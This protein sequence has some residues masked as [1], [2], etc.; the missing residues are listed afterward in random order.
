MT[1]Y[2]Y[3][4]AGDLISTTDPV[5]LTTS[6][7]Y[8]ALGRIKRTTTSSTVGGLVTY[9]ITD[10]TYNGISEV[11]TVDAPAVNNTVAGVVHT[12]R[13][14]YLYDLGG[15]KVSES[16]QDTT[17]GDTTRLTGW[18][19]D[20]HG[21]LVSTTAADGAVTSQA[22][23]I[24]GNVS[25]STKPGLSLAYT[26]DDA[27][28]LLTTTANGPG[29]DPESAAQTL[30]LEARSY[31][32]AGRLAAISDAQ[33]R[34]TRYTYYGEDQLRATAMD[35]P[36]A[37]PLVT[38]MRSYDEANHPTLVTTPAASTA[39]TYDAAGTVGTKVYDPSGLA[40]T[41]TNTYNPDGTLSRTTLITPGPTAGNVAC[42]PGDLLR[43]VYGEPDRVQGRQRELVRAGREVVLHRQFKVVADR[44]RVSGGHLQFRRAAR[45]RG[46]RGH[47]DQH[48]QL[49]HRH[50]HR[51]HELGH[52]RG[53]HRQH[54]RRDHDP[55]EYTTGRYVKLTVTVPTQNGDPAARIY[56]LDVNGT[57]G[58]PA[59]PGRTE[60]VDY[61]YDDA[62]RMLTT[63][64]DNTGGVPGSRPRRSSVIHAVW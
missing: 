11:A 28:R 41:Q 61:T 46:W 3:N 51:R 57:I 14:T 12:P 20:A 47:R 50:Q 59:S 54:G 56:E 17:G 9:G 32:P 34:V 1:T 30:L 18:A 44:P 64:I 6:Y 26:F 8:D 43:D 33:G 37:E 58:S 31:D 38:E 53:R 63:R 2:S 40:R 7:D 10:T 23:D 60:A 55:V 24:A 27:H 13:T 5:G 35:R 4:G 39:Y 15:R 49:H 45:R 62:G 21:R 22:W 29:V 42:S 52:P 19:Y 48:S 36:A 16:I 25:Q